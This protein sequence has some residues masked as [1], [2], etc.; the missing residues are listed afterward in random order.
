MIARAPA[1]IAVSNAT[2]DALA[3]QSAQVTSTPLHPA[4]QIAQAMAQK[5]QPA[6]DQ[7]IAT[8]EAMLAKATDL[9]EFQ[10]M[11]AN[12]FGD[13]DTS[14]LASVLAS[15]IASAHAAGRSDL[16]DESSAS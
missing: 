5:G 1:A 3:L 12:A 2:R 9:E 15:G 16:V 14:D 4:A 7:M 6:V 11:L 8:I 10:Q 13:I